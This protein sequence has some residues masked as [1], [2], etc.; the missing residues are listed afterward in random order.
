MIYQA[1]KNKKNMVIFQNVF[2]SKAAS[3]QPQ[4][5]GDPENLEFLE[6]WKSKIE[7]LLI[8]NG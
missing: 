7:K 6:V 1:K 8:S 5:L 4:I 2:S 3:W